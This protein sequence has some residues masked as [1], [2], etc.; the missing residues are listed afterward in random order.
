M[1]VS[2]GIKAMHSIIAFFGFENELVY[3]NEVIAHTRKIMQHRPVVLTGHSLGGG[4]ANI[5][6][7]FVHRPSIAFSAPGIRQS[8]AKFCL[9]FRLTNGTLGLEAMPASAHFVR[10]IGRDTVQV[11]LRDRDIYHRYA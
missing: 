2:Q 5:V 1:F 7:S 6:G 10:A 3:Y 11:C 9:T 8:R 4:I